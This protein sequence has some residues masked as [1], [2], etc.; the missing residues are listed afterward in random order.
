MKTKLL[1]LQK[2]EVERLKPLQQK[3][4]QN[5]QLGNQ[6]GGSKDGGHPT[7]GVNGRSKDGEHR[8]KEVGISHLTNGKVLNLPQIR[9]LMKRLKIGIMVAT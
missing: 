4:Q 5:Q 8:G 6:I 3:Q 2:V 1:E 9:F 7:G